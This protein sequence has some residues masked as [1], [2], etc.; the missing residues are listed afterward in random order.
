MP[1]VIQPGAQNTNKAMVLWDN[2]LSD[3]VITDSSG[4]DPIHPGINAIKDESTWSSWKTVEN[5]N[6]R[7]DLKVDLGEVR[8]FSALG[9]SSH[10]LG[11]D[12]ATVQLF[13]SIDGISYG[14]V[15]QSYSPIAND[16]FILLFKSYSYR[17]VLIRISGGPSSVGILSLGSPLVFPHAPVDSY[18]PLHH[19]RR[20]EKL[21]NDSLKGHFLSNRVMSAG[22]ETDVD[23]GFL[24]RNWLEL[25]IRGFERHYNQG[26]TFFYAGCPSRYPDD[27][28]YCRSAG[29]DES[30]AIEFIEGDRLSSL[31]FG[32]R[33]FVGA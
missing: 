28:G 21:Y 18:T 17:Y 20:Y 15:R 6:G 27:M 10:T 9:V 11:S 1:V 25:N 14:S 32:V 24:D 4:T 13:V 8:T 33:S 26:K 12:G 22:A 30:L 5:L 7:G 31:S 23:M 16:D 3:G 2:F 29:S 19:A